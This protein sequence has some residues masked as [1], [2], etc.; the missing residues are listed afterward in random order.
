[1][2][3][4]ASWTMK[5]NEELNAQSDNPFVP[6]LVIVMDLDKFEEYVLQHGLSQYEPNIITGELTNFIEEFAVKHRGVVIYGL[7]RDR[8]TEE[9]IIEIPFG[10]EYL[11]SII[12]DLEELKKKVEEYGVSISIAVIRDYVT[13]KPARN[14]REAYHGTPGRS[15]AIKVLKAIK[16]RGGGRILVLA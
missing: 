5:W 16:R 11:S 7:D 15:R 2:K 8:G 1:M 12:K 4:A 13:G 10:Y 9:A 6:G 14:R 3:R